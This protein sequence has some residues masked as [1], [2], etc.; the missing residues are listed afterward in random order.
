MHQRIPFLGVC[1]VTDRSI[2]ISA[3]ELSFA[4]AAD[5]SRIIKAI[6]PQALAARRRAACRNHEAAMLRADR[7][8]TLAY[9]GDAVASHLLAVSRG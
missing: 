7:L 1:N 9:A 2:F 8:T 3:L 4:P 5:E 6:S